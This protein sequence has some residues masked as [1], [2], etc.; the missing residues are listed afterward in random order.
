MSFLETYSEVK[1]A[2]GVYILCS[3]FHYFAISLLSLLD[4]IINDYI[5]LFEF[6][7]ICS[8]SEVLL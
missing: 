4:H 7:R 3:Q 2:I 6:M 8:Y 1:V 5:M